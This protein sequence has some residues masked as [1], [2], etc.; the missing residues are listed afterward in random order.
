MYR[1]QAT[2]RNPGALGNSEQLDCCTIATM[3]RTAA[4][5]NDT[6]NSPKSNSFDWTVSGD[7]TGYGWTFGEDGVHDAGFTVGIRASLVNAKEMPGLDGRKRALGIG[8]GLAYN[9]K[10]GFSHHVGVTA[11]IGD[12]IPNPIDEMLGLNDQDRQTTTQVNDPNRYP[13]QFVELDGSFL[14]FTFPGGPITAE[15][16]ANRSTSQAL[17]ASLEAYEYQRRKKQLGQIVAVGKQLYEI[18]GNLWDWGADVYQQ[19]M[20]HYQTVQSGAYAAQSIWDTASTI[21]GYLYDGFTDAYQQ[22][23]QMQQLMNAGVEGVQYLTDRAT[24]YVNSAVDGLLNYFSSWVDVP[25]TQTSGTP[26]IPRRSEPNPSENARRFFDLVD[27]ERQ[28]PDSLVIDVT[29]LT[30]E[31]IQAIFSSRSYSPDDIPSFATFLLRKYDKH[32]PAFWTG[33]QGGLEGTAQGLLNTVNGVQD[34]GIGLLNLPSFVWNWT[35]GWATGAEIPYI[36][37]PDWSK[38][39]VFNEGDTSHAV[40]KFLTGEGAS[41][42]LLGGI[43]QLNKLRHLDKVDDGVPFLD[44][45]YGVRTLP[46]STRGWHVGDPINNLTS[47]GDV[48]SWTAVR[49]RIWKNEAYYRSGKYDV[50]D[51]IRMQQGLPPTRI[52]PEAGLLERMELHHVPPQREGGLFDVHRLWESQHRRVDPFRR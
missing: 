42:L 52:N 30:E 44:G 20:H 25:P 2:V 11:H 3:P 31:E 51:R 38:G 7:S 9:S 10:S 18:G 35:G 13:F 6:H 34:A 41:T 14:G 50:L 4:L 15:G 45:V 49:E 39:L 43:N 12:P 32:A 27:A 19:T 47:K 5:N 24:P 16:M 17:Q 48:P 46:N 37:S 29:G 8:G 1:F 21:G 26:N 36:P 28:N 40:S 22:T 23:V 33:S